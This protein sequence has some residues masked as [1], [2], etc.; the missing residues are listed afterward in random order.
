MRNQVSSISCVYTSLIMSLLLIK[1]SIGSSNTK[2]LLQNL[3]QGEIVDSWSLYLASD[4]KAFLLYT[5]LF[6]TFGHLN[7]FF[8]LFT[9]LKLHS[10]LN[11]WLYFLFLFLFSLPFI[12]YYKFTQPRHLFF[13]LMNTLFFKN[14]P[15]KFWYRESH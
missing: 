5:D 3:I 8:L 12:F 14:W 6:V 1:W 7:R 10:F 13:N 15:Y 2:T 11:M 9:I 4:Y